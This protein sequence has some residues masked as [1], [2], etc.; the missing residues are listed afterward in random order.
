L[1]FSLFINSLATASFTLWI[2]SAAES[3]KWVVHSPG[4]CHRAGNE[5]LVFNC[6]ESNREELVFQVRGKWG[7]TKFHAL[8]SLKNKRK[9][10]RNSNL[11]NCSS[12]SWQLQKQSFPPF[13]YTL[14]LAVEWV[15]RKNTA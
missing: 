12:I 9:K 11:Y 4:Q 3:C 1:N 10:K 15:I 8:F 5:L 7:Y 13:F 14:I 6:C 2:M